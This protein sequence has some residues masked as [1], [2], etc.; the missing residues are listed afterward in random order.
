[1]ACNHQCNQGRACTCAITA[2]YA[3]TEGVMPMATGCSTKAPPLNAGQLITDNSDG[4]S[5][6]EPTP[7][8]RASVLRWFVVLAVFTA[9]AAMT[10]RLAGQF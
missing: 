6:D 1:M 8:P 9:A 3:E 10:A 7:T 5:R 2:F 4:S